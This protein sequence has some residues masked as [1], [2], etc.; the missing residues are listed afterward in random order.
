MRKRLWLVLFLSGCAVN[1]LSAPANPPK[2]LVIQQPV[3]PP[4]AALPVNFQAEPQLAPPAVAQTITP[5]AIVAVPAPTPVTQGNLTDVQI[6]ELG[7]AIHVITEPPGASIEVNG[8]V[9]DGVSPGRF[10]A[11]RK[12]N[13]Y[14]YLPRL[15]IVVRPPE[16]SV[17]LYP[18]KKL[19]DGYTAAPDEINFNMSVP[20]PLPMIDGSQ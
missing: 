14:G 8:K 19:F 11:I 15:T 2:P 16:G 1:Q 4:I 9:L 17:G 6:K 20:P 7:Q 10:F 18:Q 12:P 5:T 3:A 13:K